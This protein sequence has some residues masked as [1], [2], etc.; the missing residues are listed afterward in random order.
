ME[1]SDPGVGAELAIKIP[2][3][4]TLALG[5]GTNDDTKAKVSNARPNA[6]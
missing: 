6:G 5:F 1:A 4:V 3:F 2:A